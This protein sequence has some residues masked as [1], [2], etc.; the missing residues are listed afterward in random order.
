MTGP[1]YEPGVDITVLGQRVEIPRLV[2]DNVN[3]LRGLGGIWVT[4]RARTAIGELV[5]VLVQHVRFTTE[6]FSSGARDV[7]NA[8]RM[9]LVISFISYI[10]NI[11]KIL[12][13]LTL[14]F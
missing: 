4:S 1:K 2:Y 9:T 10:S 11:I 5:S 12:Q 13:I 14:L 6:N 8:F 3:R 7:T